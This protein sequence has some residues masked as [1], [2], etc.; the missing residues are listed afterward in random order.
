MEQ[1]PRLDIRRAAP[2]GVAAMLNVHQYLSN[3]GLEP[4]LLDIVYLRASQ[5]NGCAYCTDMHW[6]DARAAGVDEQKL[7]L[8]PAWRE[9]PFFTERERAALAW[10]ESVTLLA[11][12]RVP[13]EDFAQVREQFSDAEIANLTLAIGVIN[14][15]NRL[16]VSFRTPAGSYQVGQHA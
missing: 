2:K 3:C 15:W 13:D 11:S 9:A 12:T 7:S 6:K 4:A 10:T 1:Q 16:N 5:I 14:T 8:V